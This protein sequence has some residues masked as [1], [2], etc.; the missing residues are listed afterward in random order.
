[1]LNE[2][3]RCLLTRVNFFTIIFKKRN[4]LFQ[5]NGLPAFRYIFLFCAT[6]PTLHKKDA[7][8]IGANLKTSVFQTSFFWTK[9][10]K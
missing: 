7:A 6:V 10:S 3:N 8:A 4:T 9:I 1:L 5:L 2:I